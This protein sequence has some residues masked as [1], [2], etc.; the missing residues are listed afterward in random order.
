[1]IT[2]RE[3]GKLALAAVP[4]SAQSSAEA[5]G[6]GIRLGVDTFSFRDLLRTPGLDNVDD[7]IKALQ[8]VGAREIV[9]SSVNTEP[10]G[11]NSG[12]A[13]PPPPSAYPDPIKAPSPAEVAAARL[14]V[15]NDLRKWRLATPPE[16]HEAVRAKFQAAEID[17]FAY[18]VDYDSAFTDD[19]IDVT[20]RQAKALGVRTIASLTTL[21]MARRLAPFAAKY[22]LTIAL[23][24]TANVKDADAIATPQSFRAALGL[25]PNFRLNFDIGNFTAANFEAVAFLQENQA[26]I[27][28]IQI[29]DRTRNGGGDEKFGDGDT[30]IRDV[31]A[32][33]KSKQLPIPVFVEY[34][35][36]G[37]G[38]PQQEVRKCLAFARSALS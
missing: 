30:P 26:S 8:S 7:V 14:A 19:E 21:G 12:P 22:G 1:M 9:L 28:H 15:R 36:I 31:L 24:N 25:S 23:H 13:V 17:V 18:R 2:R 34:E 29:K 10:A 33:V 6:S 35:Y 20:F 11:P 16:K 27:S 4:F 5:A 37:L 32:V 38:T 3:L